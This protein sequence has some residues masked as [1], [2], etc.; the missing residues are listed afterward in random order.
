[1]MRLLSIRRHF[2]SSPQFH[3][4]TRL[5]D[6]FVFVVGASGFDTPSDCNNTYVSFLIARDIALLAA[7]ATPASI[8]S[9]VVNANSP[10]HPFTISALPC[11]I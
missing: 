6:I 3:S 9:L 2:Q 11:Q 10:P 8:G 4:A 1:M 5:F 7:Q